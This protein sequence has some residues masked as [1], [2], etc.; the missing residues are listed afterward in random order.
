MHDAVRRWLEATVGG[1]IVD[2]SSW[3][4]LLDRPAR[5]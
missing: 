4:E 2:A 5:P 3:A 1:S